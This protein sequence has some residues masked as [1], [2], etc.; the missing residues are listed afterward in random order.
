MKR[1]LLKTGKILSVGA[2][3]VGLAACS[4]NEAKLQQEIDRLSVELAAYKQEE[5][6]VKANL[7][8]MRQ[9]DDA[10]NRRDWDTFIGTH[11]DDVLVTSPD[12]PVP[13]NNKPD[14]LAVVKGFTDAFPDHKIQL[15]YVMSIGQGDSFC[16]VHENGGTFSEPWKLPNG[17][18][19]PPTNK[20]Y[21]M[22]MVT[23]GKVKDGKITEEKII[24]DMVGMMRQLGMM[25]D[26]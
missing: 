14:H 10:M 19:I 23:L 17:Q 11:S 13:T 12:S 25:G 9:T 26:H 21:T 7:E 2:I 20:K 1:V 16:A 24:Y 3:V 18:V 6:T 4:S 15:P 8:L 5:A 22:T